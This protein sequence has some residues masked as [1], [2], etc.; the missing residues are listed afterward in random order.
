MEKPF[1]RAIWENL[2][3]ISKS[4]ESLIASIEN[5]IGE[6]GSRASAIQK[7]NAAYQDIIQACRKDQEYRD[8]QKSK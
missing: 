2:E 7:L 4:I 3:P 8:Q 5:N 6:S 1:D